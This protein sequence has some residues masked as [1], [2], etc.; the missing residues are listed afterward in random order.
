MKKIIALVLAALMMFTLVAPASAAED[1]KIPD[2]VVEKVVQILPAEI[3]EKINVFTVITSAI[4]DFVHKVVGTIT[5]V[6]GSS[7]PFCDNGTH[8]VGTPSAKVTVL[9]EKPVVVVDGEEITLD[10]AYNFEPSESLTKQT[11]NFANWHADYV[12]TTSKD[13]KNILFAGQYDSWSENY[14]GFVIPE[15]KA[16]EEVRLLEDYSAEF[17]GGKKIYVNCDEI[18]NKIVSFNC[19]LYNNDPANAGATITVEL[20]LY[21]TYPREETGAL[22]STNVETGR[23]VTISTIPCTISAV[24]A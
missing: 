18:F 17:S 4:K 14:V 24:A 6:V 9:E 1:I 11:E 12:I 5:Q 10:V 20:R 23:F 7:C 3:T 13:V 19:G 22:N 8:L 15:I 2:E 21:E 16:G